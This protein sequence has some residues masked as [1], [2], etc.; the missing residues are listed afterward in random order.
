MA[1]HGFRDE[2][3]RS[4]AAPDQVT[5]AGDAIL[6]RGRSCLSEWMARNARC[7]CSHAAI[8][9]APN[10]VLETAPPAAR[11][12]TLSAVRADRHAVLGNL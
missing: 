11:L 12:R 4:P 5:K 10:V 9:L 2:A 8:L 7:A 1:A 3:G 6:S